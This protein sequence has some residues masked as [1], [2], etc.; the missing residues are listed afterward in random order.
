MVVDDVV[1]AREMLAE[2]LRR[3]GYCVIEAAT[4][5]EAIDVL[6][7]RCG[8]GDCCPDL[9]LLDIDLPD[10]KGGTIAKWVREAFPHVAIVLLTAY[11][12]LP[13]FETIAR[14]VN[15]PLMTKPVE[16]TELLASVSDTL[17][18]YQSKRERGRTVSVPPLLR[19]HIEEVAQRRAV[20]GGGYLL[21]YGGDR[22]E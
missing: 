22:K 8:R 11:G 2:C 7:E 3:A 14:E 16:L 21:D 6:N 1:D 12:R 15:A 19:A 4:G 10:I 20:T 5:G 9:I 18:D 13:A 17:R